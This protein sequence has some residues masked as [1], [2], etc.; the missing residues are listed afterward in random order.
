VERYPSPNDARGLGSKRLDAFLARHTYCGRRPTEALL[1]RL[2]SAPVAVVGE[3]EAD[4]RRAAVLGL[5]AALRPIVE[6]IRQ[7]TSQIAG[8]VR[9]HPDAAIFLSLFRDPKSVVCAAG[10]LAEIGDNRV[11]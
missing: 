8:A 1:D 4:A 6:Q 7:L 10:L 2:R 3:L 5:V 9:A 11:R